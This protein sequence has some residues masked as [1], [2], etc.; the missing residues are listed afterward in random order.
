[1]TF[2]L[3]VKTRSNY[4]ADINTIDGVNWS[5]SFGL[6]CEVLA[7]NPKDP[8]NQIIKALEAERPS[9]KYLF[10]FFVTLG[11][12]KF[13]GIELSQDLICYA[14]RRVTHAQSFGVRT[15]RNAAA[16]LEALGLIS[17]AWVP[18]G[19]RVDIGGG[20]WR[21]AQV[22]RYSIKEKL[23]S[24]IGLFARDVVKGRI[25]THKK[26]HLLTA[27]KISDNPKG[28][29]TEGRCLDDLPSVMLLQTVE[30]LTNVDSIEGGAVSGNEDETTSTAPPR[31]APS[32]EHSASRVAPTA[33]KSA[34]KGGLRASV[35]YS[36]ARAQFLAEL[37]AFL[38]PAGFSA[39][40]TVADITTDARYPGEL[41]A[42]ITAQELLRWYFLS[43]G[44]RRKILSRYF[45]PALD[46]FVN[47]WRPPADAASFESW[48]FYLKPQNMPVD[49]WRFVRAALSALFD[50]KTDLNH[51]VSMLWRWCGVD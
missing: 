27:E 15:L 23:K 2:A 10:E 12:C 3:A 43:W 11:R 51:T 14:V 18:I 37:F 38:K 16:R 17:A 34:K 48:Q 7:S 24:M 46:V 33:R 8:R 39:V 26:L 6:L 4:W 13:K 32:V 22:R 47:C 19:K 5:D 9:V 28:E 25:K 30:N 41:P 29:Q 50:G 42:P 45:V 44:E 20:A 21:T 1:M 49:G 35:S 36:R 31:A 40:Y